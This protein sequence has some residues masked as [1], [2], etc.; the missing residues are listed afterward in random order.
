[1]RLASAPGTRTLI[2]AVQAGSMGAT[3]NGIQVQL[4]EFVPPEAD[5]FALQEGDGA[6]TRSSR[7]PISVSTTVPF[8]VVLPQR[9]PTPPI[10]DQ[11]T[12]VLR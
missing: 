5:V 10:P 6:G 7:S 3:V 9:P 4:P 12:A 1:M 2:D 8:E 11:G